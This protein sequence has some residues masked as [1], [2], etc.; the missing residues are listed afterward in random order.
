MPAPLYQTKPRPDAIYYEQKPD[1]KS[2]LVFWEG[3]G[4]YALTKR[5]PE[6]VFHRVG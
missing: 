1:T 4:W 6:T 3:P 5:G 2:K